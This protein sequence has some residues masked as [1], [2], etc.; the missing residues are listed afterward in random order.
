MNQTETEDKTPSAEVSDW[1]DRIDYA[2]EKEKDWRK[3]GEQVFKIYRSE[4]KGSSKKDRFNILWTNTE[5]KRQSLINATPIPDI[6]R[7]FNDPDPVGGEACEVLKRGISYT[8]DCQDGLNKLFLCANDMLLPGRGVIRV[9]Y[10]GYMNESDDVNEHVDSDQETTVPEVSY[11]EAQ[12]EHVQWDK[13]IHSTGD[14]WADIEKDGWVGFIHDI[15]KEEAK[16]RWPEK[17]SSLSYDS[18]EKDAKKEENAEYK[19]TTVYE[20]WDKDEK[21]VYWI[22]KDYK[23][24]FLDIIDDP[25]ELKGFFPVPRPAYAI[26]DSTSLV[27]II[28]YS[29]YEVLAKELEDLTNR[30]G[31][32]INAC[33]ARG[34]YDARI[35]EME[36]LFSADDNEFIPLQNAVAVMETGGLEKNIYFMPL[37]IIINAITVLNNQRIAVKQ[38]IEEI[39]GM[40][41]I[42]RGTTNPNETATA[43]RIKV[44]FASARLD[45]QKQTFQVFARDLIRII[46]DVISQFSRDTISVMTGLTYQTEQ[47][48]QMMQAQLQMIQQ[49]MQPQMPGMPP[50]Q[51]NPQMA[52][53][54]QQLQAELQKPSWEQVSAILKSDMTREYK[55]D[56]ETDST[57]AADKQAMQETLSTFMQAIAQFTTMA[58]NGEQAGVLTQAAAKEMMKEF[59]RG[60]GLSKNIEEALDKQDPPKQDPEAAKMQAEM[61]MQQQQHQMDMQAQQQKAQSEQQKMQ[62]ELQVKQQ[63]AQIEIQK[64]Q[65]EL[66]IE[67]EKLAMQREQMQMDQQANV[68]K[69]A[70]D[71]KNMQMKNEHDM[72]THH[73][74]MEAMSEQKPDNG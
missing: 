70:M 50:Q 58:A 8:L 4:S 66:Q 72:Q 39:T 53:Q 56:I 40:S 41:D 51:P 28:E 7:R 61:Q 16:E 46:A 20:I 33:R 26:E 21:K 17:Y 14:E 60:F 12:L 1:L 64:M 74:K 69:M 57:I 43:Q 24:D 34:A 32:L 47:E 73:M 62:L 63:E 23:D 36:K 27:P 65:M 55:I 15:T 42:I 54:A 30:I 10:K 6:R 49:Q 44:N 18:N 35:S 3:D 2:L 29:Q 9:R 19:T 25:M 67:K 52:Q 38:Q 48:K 68:L 5:I 71:A 59:V 13:F 31:K 11:E 22:G 45:R 37:E